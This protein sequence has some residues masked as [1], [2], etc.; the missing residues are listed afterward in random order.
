MCFRD[1]LGE[2]CI[3]CFELGLSFGLVIF[4]IFVKRIEDIYGKLIVNLD[5]K[6]F[7]SEFWVL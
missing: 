1:C 6:V 3:G 7:I 2:D 4:E 5:F